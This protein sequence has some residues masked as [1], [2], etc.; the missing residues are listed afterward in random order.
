VCAS[1]PKERAEGT[2]SVIHTSLS[3]LNSLALHLNGEPSPTFQSASPKKSPIIGTLFGANDDD[4]VIATFGSNSEDGGDDGPI[5]S[6][7][8]DTVNASRATL[9]STSGDIRLQSDTTSLRQLSPHSEWVDSKQP[10]MS[11][12]SHGTHTS[13]P[14]YLQLSTSPHLLHPQP[15][16]RPF[17]GCLFLLN[18]S[19]LKHE[20]SDICD[21]DG[22]KA[23]HVAREIGR[24]TPGH[25]FTRVI[26]E[27]HAMRPKT[28]IEECGS[29]RSASGSSSNH[30]G[31]SPS[32]L[33]SSTHL[34]YL[35]GTNSSVPML[36]VN[37]E[38]EPARQQAQ[39]YNALSLSK[40]LPPLP[41]AT[42]LNPMN[43]GRRPSA[44]D[45]KRH[46]VVNQAVLGMLFG[47]HEVVAPATAGSAPIKPLVLPPR[48][49]SNP[50]LLSPTSTV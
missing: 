41:F 17:Q 35:T 37:R 50:G 31:A 45:P 5:L 36:G 30:T 42:A 12:M 24:E 26:N 40:A 16:P 18:E 8:F 32:P 22:C 1:P 25:K 27:Q 44:E 6:S 15:R 4:E 46:A 11:P 20:P 29:L 14:N 48:A 28:I 38:D 3:P 39:R 2:S 19:E 10:P 43:T 33:P 34:A 13:H 21:C 49:M 7:Q 47:N 23:R 9:N